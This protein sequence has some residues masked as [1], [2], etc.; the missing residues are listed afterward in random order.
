[1]VYNTN[2]TENIY[3]MINKNTNNETSWTFII[4]VLILL[5]VAFYALSL[6]LQYAWNNSISKIFDIRNITAS[7]SIY[8]MIV[9]MILFGMGK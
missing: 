6:F 1:M 5:V 2:I 3:H 7:E 8:L 4:L 9:A